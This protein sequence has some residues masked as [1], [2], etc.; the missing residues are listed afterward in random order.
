MK[1]TAFKFPAQFGRLKK[2]KTVVVRAKII[3]C[4]ETFTSEMWF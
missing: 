4:R 2:K 1:K 3:V